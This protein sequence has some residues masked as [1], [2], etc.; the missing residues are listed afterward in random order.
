M[1]LID[2]HCHLEA[3]EFEGNLDSLLSDARF[4]GVQKL[5]TASILPEQWAVSR[6]IAAR[7]SEVAFA[8]GIHPWYVREEHVALV[9]GL[10]E[11]RAAGAC[12]IGEIG[13]DGKIESPVLGLQLRVFER[14]L[15]IAK[16]LEL[17]VVLHCRGAFNELLETLKRIGAP[18]RG[19]VIHAFS[20]S[21]EVA[22]ACLRYGL[23]FS[24]G[25]ALTYHRSNKRAKTLKRIYP[26]H[27]LLETDSPDIPPVQALGRPNVPANIRYNLQGAAAY[28]GET[29]EAIAAQTTR[30]AVALFGFVL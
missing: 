19:G 30:N 17:P 11:A 14:Q 26:D 23:S 2:V 21:V 3:E 18:E 10:Y 27:F 16:E 24:M 12:A 28:L 1:Q 5:V 25:G 4:A 22:E 13:L 29:E 20:G 7:Y 6:D 15:V 8:W 9:E